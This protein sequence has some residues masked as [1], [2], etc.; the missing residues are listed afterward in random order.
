M[1]QSRAP[2]DS[3]LLRK[4]EHVDAAE[5]AIAAVLNKLFERGNGG[6]VG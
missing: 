2:V 4:I 5:L 1:R 6:A 3:G